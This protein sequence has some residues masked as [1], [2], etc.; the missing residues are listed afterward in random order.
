MSELAYLSGKSLLDGEVKMKAKKSETNYS[1]TGTVNMLW[2]DPYDGHEGQSFYI[3]RS[4]ERQDHNAI[5][6]E[7][8][9]GSKSFE[10]RSEWKLGFKGEYNSKKTR[11]GKCQMLRLNK[12]CRVC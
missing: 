5:F 10:L 3:P 9:G 2:H 8:H 4:G 11:M 7:R 12:S 6:L 1:M